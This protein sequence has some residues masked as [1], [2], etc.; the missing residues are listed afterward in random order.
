M[1]FEM[2]LEM[3]M[4]CGAVC[5]QGDTYHFSYDMDVDFSEFGTDAL[6][7]LCVLLGHDVSACPCGFGE[8]V[9]DVFKADP[10][11]KYLDEADCKAL[12]KEMVEN[13]KEYLEPYYDLRG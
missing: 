5:K 6:G 10:L 4:A 1:M 12:F 9:Y 3:A 7:S 11:C 8:L 2:V 13:T